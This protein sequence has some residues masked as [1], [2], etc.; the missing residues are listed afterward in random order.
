MTMTGVTMMMII[1]MATPGNDK[2]LRSW[3]VSS[4]PDTFHGSVYNIFV[5]PTMVI[6]YR[7]YYFPLYSCE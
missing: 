1:M 2:Q 3:R 6:S 4:M 5:A 7:A